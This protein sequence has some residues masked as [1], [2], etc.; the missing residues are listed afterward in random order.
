MPAFRSRF[1][2][3]QVTP[4]VILFVER[5]GSTYLATALASHPEILALREQFSQM[6]QQGKTAAE[7]L[8][9]ARQFWTPPLVGPHA[10]LGFKTKTSDI[11]E[12][13]EFH[14]LL[15]EKGAKVI[16]LIRRNTV[17]GAISTINA[18]RLHAASG[19]WNLLN[20]SERQPVAP[21]DPGDLQREIT[22]RQKWDREL[23]DY[24]NLVDRPTLRLEY[25][26]LLQD[27]GGF[28][29]R[30]FEFLNVTPRQVEG[31]T[32]KNTSDDLREAVPNF[33]VLRA[34]FAGTPFAKMFDEVSVGTREFQS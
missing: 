20:E 19:N 5:A 11:P 32:L 10:A 8:D 29:L 9:W 4:F 18:R 26:D 27:E 14:R 3:P 24:V 34:R 6:R 2:R 7:Q 22:L 30:V 21:I 16:Q 15:D 17:K 31:K 13:V 23:E 1:F 25:E 12:A 33:D 28:M